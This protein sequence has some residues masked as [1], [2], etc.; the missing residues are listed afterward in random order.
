[1][2]TKK[3][4][5]NSAKQKVACDTV[6]GLLHKSAPSVTLVILSNT[7]S[8]KV[9]QRAKGQMINHTNYLTLP[10]KMC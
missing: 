5:E 4:L 9:A 10:Y 6:A 7:H 3:Q 2:P 8:Q 1:M